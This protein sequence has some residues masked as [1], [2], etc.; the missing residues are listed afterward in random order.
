MKLWKKSQESRKQKKKGGEGKGREK[1]KGSIE[2]ASLQVIFI[3]ICF[4]KNK[5]KISW[6]QGPFTEP[7]KKDW[8]K[9]P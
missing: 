5:P 3:H 8:W 6:T 7:P 1:K 2:F 4:Q 9:V